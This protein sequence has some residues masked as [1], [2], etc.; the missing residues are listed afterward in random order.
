MGPGVELERAEAAGD[1]YAASNRATG[2][3]IGVD[4]A[5]HGWPVESQ[6][7]FDERS[8]MGEPDAQKSTRS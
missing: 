2:E 4:L 8:A 7:L 5:V 1:R 3:L 6:V